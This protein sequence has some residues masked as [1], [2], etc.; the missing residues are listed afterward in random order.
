M[1]ISATE[2]NVEVL[3]S[4]YMA[5]CTD[6]HLINYLASSLTSVYVGGF[7]DGDTSIYPGDSVVARSIALGEPVIYVSANYRLSGTISPCMM[8][9]K[10]LHWHLSSFWIP[11]REGGASCKYRKYRS[12]RSYASHSQ[13]HYC[14][15]LTSRRAFRFRMGSQTHCCLQR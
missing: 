15:K 8:M 1:L 13:I 14:T 10:G 3:F 6:S 5:V 2:T 4:G 11:R 9:M 7:Q 12:Q